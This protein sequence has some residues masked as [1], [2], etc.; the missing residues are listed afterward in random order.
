MSATVAIVGRPNVGKSTLFNRLVGKRLALVDDTPGVTR[1]RREGDARLGDLEFTVVDTAGLEEA[2]ADSLTARMRAQTEEAIRTASAILF[3]VDA[4]VGV[5]PLDEHFAELAR[6]SG[7]PVI[8]VANKAEG[9]VGTAG[10][11]EA[12]GLGFGDPVPLS[13]E[14]GEGLADLHRILKVMLPAA[15]LEDDEA[16]EEVAAQAEP[17]ETP[18]ETLPT[19]RPVRLAVIGR[20]NVGKSTLVNKLLGEE[21]LLTGP[22]PGITRDAIA[23]SW[24]WENHSFELIDTAGLRRKARIEERP[25]RLASADT[26]RTIREAQ[27]VI[28]VLDATVMLEKQDL[29]IARHVTEEGRA[30]VVAASKWDLV[31]DRGPALK[32]LRDR[33]ET[34]LPQ[35]KGVPFVTVSGLAGT[36]LDR[37][38]EAVVAAEQRWNTK[39][40]TAPLN[41]WLADATEAHPPPMVRGRRPRLRYATQTATRP[42]TFTFFGVAPD[43]LPDD[44]VRYLANG[45]RETFDLAGMP[46]RLHFRAGRNPYVDTAGQ[47]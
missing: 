22:E 24:T 33:L 10:A 1:D 30:L 32:R 43:V 29:T 4:R 44:Y 14:H 35:V 26:L 17:H 2:E 31:E 13:A 12:Y 21:R 45:L 11:Y 42:P 46:I 47:G 28:L 38:M 37:L 8:L 40:T 9:R 16:T 6:R 5:T 34:S 7:R 23:I 25:E 20:P 18:A 41:R 19:A 27:V 15:V 39:V 3:L 36:G